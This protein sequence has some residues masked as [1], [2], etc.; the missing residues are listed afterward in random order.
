M[1]RVIK[2]L[3]KMG[4]VIESDQHTPPLVIR[5]GQTLTPIS[6]EMPIASAQVKSCV[7]LAGL[8]ASG[9]TSVK[10]LRQRE[11]ILSEC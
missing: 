3:E 7:L 9:K 8:Y 2:P 5:G 6:Y 4:A 10:G 1:G 11:T